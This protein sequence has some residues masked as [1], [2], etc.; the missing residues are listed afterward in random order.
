MQFYRNASQMFGFLKDVFWNFAKDLGWETLKKK[1]D[2]VRNI[3]MRRKIYKRQELHIKAYEIF[4][5]LEDI[6]GNMVAT[7]DI[8]RK[9]VMPLPQSSLLP[10]YLIHTT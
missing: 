3:L 8:F 7:Q 6:L 5:K 2:H 9:E 4:S 10:Q 1:L